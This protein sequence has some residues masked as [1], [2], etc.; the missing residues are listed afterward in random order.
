MSVLKIKKQ[1]RFLLTI[2]TILSVNAFAMQQQS[3]TRRNEPVNEPALTSHKDSILAI[4]DH[5]IDEDYTDFIDLGHGYF[6]LANCRLHLFKDKEQW[7]IVFEKCAYNARA[8]NPVQL[9][10]IYFGNCLMNLPM[11][12][13]KISNM[14]FVDMKNNIFEA[15]QKKETEIR[16]S[17]HSVKIPSDPET[18]RKYH[19]DLPEDGNLYEGAVLKYLA[20]T[21][22]E[23]T[24]AST[25]EIRKCLPKNLKE[26]LTLDEWHQEEYHHFAPTVP[27]S[28]QET[29]QMIAKVLET[30][31]T[32]FYKP[33]KK[34]NTH[35]SNWPESGGL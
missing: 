12:N 27:P 21:H 29:F 24:R 20:E 18:Y 19:I 5:S 16:I 26:I 2:A 6:E 7:A 14:D 4:L 33:T 1:I 34:P 15:I 13:G 8:G 11:E 22:P 32:T 17:G 10:L 25:E 3:C 35:W 9:Q 31:D 23:L 28:K 30:G